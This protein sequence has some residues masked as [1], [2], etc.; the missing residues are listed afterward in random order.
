MLRENCESRKGWACRRI[1]PDA[2]PFGEEGKAFGYVDQL[3]FVFGAELLTAQQ[4]YVDTLETVHFTLPP[5]LTWSGPGRAVPPSGWQ[6]QPLFE[7]CAES[8]QTATCEVGVPAGSSGSFAWLFDVTAKK[9]GYYRPTVEIGNR[10]VNTPPGEATPELVHLLALVRDGG[11]KVPGPVTSKL[12]LFNARLGKA[13]GLRVIS[14]VWKGGLP[15]RPSA[16]PK[17]TAS[18]GGKRLIGSIG[19]EDGMGYRPGHVAIWRFD[20]VFLDAG[21]GWA[22]CDFYLSPSMR[23]K[24]AGKRLTGRISVKVGRKRTTKRYSVPIHASGIWVAHPG[25]EP[26]PP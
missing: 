14:L 23:R 10:D 22:F 5:G 2:P 26:P 18:A 20:G 1:I 6:F 8:G 12:V 7:S 16:D 19:N 9:S 15:V 3:H 17:C 13:H 24:Y 4:G 11:D 25:H 21:Y